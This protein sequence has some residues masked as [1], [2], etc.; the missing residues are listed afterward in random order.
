MIKLVAFDWN[1][2]LLS[3][4]LTA[5]NADNKVL[6]EFGLKP[7][8]LQKF[9]ECFDM[10]IQKYW[11]SLGFDE[12]FFLA[13]SKTIHWNFNKYYEPMADKCRTR[14]GARELL[15][16]LKQE[17][18]GAVIYSNHIIPAIEKQ[19]KR[20][21]LNNYFEQILARPSEHD[22]SHMH[23]RSKEQKLVD[24]IKKHKLKP[25]EVLSVGDTEEEIEI[26]K[27]HGFY[28]AAITGGYNTA[29]R[30]KKHKPDF[31]I[32]TLRS[33]VTTVKNINYL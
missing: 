25:E 10:P 15:K 16:Y 24:Y 4:S 27:Q 26:G 19:L 28:T 14:A 5:T 6:T 33:L 2:T 3:D 23:N 30:L 12:K 13:N 20:L 22:F 17:K 8:T 32:H 11:V 18:I 21:K 9:R 7:I 1:G 31:L 29:A